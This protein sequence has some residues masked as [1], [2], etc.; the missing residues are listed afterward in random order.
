MV[1]LK[2]VA[3]KQGEWRHVVMSWKN[4]DSGKNDA[5]SQL[6]ID[7]KLIG[8]IKDRAIGMK[9]DVDK[10]GIYVA[11]NYIG[12]L[13]ELAL[14]DEAA[15]VLTAPVLGPELLGGRPRVVRERH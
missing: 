15:D 14:P 10:A 8:E 5:V 7:G 4:F 3:F 9:W 13:D 12:L 11:V 2:R 1:W 6:W